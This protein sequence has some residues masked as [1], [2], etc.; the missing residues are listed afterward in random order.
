MKPLADIKGRRGNTADILSTPFANKGFR[1]RPLILNVVV[2]G[3]SNRE[4]N[5]VGVGGPTPAWQRP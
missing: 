3:L 1:G 2:I 5:D 4:I